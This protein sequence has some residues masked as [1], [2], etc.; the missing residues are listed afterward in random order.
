MESGWTGG[1]AGRRGV[2]QWACGWGDIADCRMI[3]GPHLVV[4]QALVSSPSFPDSILRVT[5]K[6]I[7]E[8]LDPASG[9]GPVLQSS[10]FDIEGMKQKLSFIGI[11]NGAGGC[12]V[13]SLLIKS[14]IAVT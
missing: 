10:G 8:I 1:L 4:L 14:D 6:R 11:S 12:L 2:A 5:G 9:L 3:A 13:M 7:A